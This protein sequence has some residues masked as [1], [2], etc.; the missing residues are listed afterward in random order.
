[1]LIGVLDL[2][3]RSARLDLY[4]EVAL[5]DKFDISHMGYES[6]FT[7][8]Y[9]IVVQ[10]TIRTTVFEIYYLGTLL[11]GSVKSLLICFDF[12]QHLDQFYSIINYS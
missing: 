3:L 12:S 6:N 2:G 11:R 7:L 5:F 4:L 8:F 9:R 1:M 10:R